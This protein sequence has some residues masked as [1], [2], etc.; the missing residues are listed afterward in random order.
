MHDQAYR[1]KVR[2]SLPHPNRFH[3][4]MMMPYGDELLVVEVLERNCVEERLQVFLEEY[5]KPVILVTEQLGEVELNRE[6]GSYEGEGIWNGKMFS[7]SG[8][9]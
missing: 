7:V 3:R 9:G 6:F 4:E 5:Q 1:M 2:A 8:Y